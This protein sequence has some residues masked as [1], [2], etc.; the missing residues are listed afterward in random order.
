MVSPYVHVPPDLDRDGIE[1]YRR[2][3]ERLLNRLTLE[4]EAWAEA[5]TRK[6]EQLPVFRQP[7]AYRPG[8][9][10]R[11]LEAPGRTV[12]SNRAVA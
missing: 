11:I 7:A 8:A 1:H 4:A 10:T 2:R 3:V 9:L 6:I 12:A 5:G